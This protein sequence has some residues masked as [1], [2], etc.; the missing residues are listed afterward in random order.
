MASPTIQGIEKVL[1]VYWYEGRASQAVRMLKYGSATQLAGAMA[2]FM[3]LAY[4]QDFADQI[5][6]IVP[7]PIHWTRRF[8]RGFNQSEMLAMAL[9]ADKLFCK[10]L[11]RIKPTSAQAS[12]DRAHRLN[13][14]KGAFNASKAVHG[15]RILLVD[16][17]IT[18]GATIEQCGHAL[19]LAGAKQVNALSFACVP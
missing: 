18:T 14:L 19:K 1:S 11:Q 12:L 8:E 6:W 10:G 4:T 16:D 5:D 7:V 2:D 9:P 17:V 15:K 3:A 13:S